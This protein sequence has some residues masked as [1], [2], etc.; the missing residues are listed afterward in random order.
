MSF[1]KRPGIGVNSPTIRNRCVQPTCNNRIRREIAR[2]HEAASVRRTAPEYDLMGD[3]TRYWNEDNTSLKYD[4]FQNNLVYRKGLELSLFGSKRKT[5]PQSIQKKY[6]NSLIRKIYY[7]GGIQYEGNL[8]DVETIHAA[9]DQASKRKGLV[10][11]TRHANGQ[12]HPETCD[13]VYAL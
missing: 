10:T 8:A 11:G 1:D 6:Q 3:H 4:D 5:K 2:N 13:G 12:T 9:K 7:Q